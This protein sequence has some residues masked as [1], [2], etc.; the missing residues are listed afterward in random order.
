[1]ELRYLVIC[2][3][4]GVKS[5][6]LLQFKNEEGKWEFVEFIEKKSWEDPYSD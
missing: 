2:T 6:P 3:Q 1:M 5:E 4:H